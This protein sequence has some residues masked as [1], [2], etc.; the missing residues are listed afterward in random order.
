MEILAYIKELLLLNDCVIIPGFGGFVSN[1]KPATVR[2][3][4]FNPP[5]KAISFNEKLTFNDGLLINHL[6]EKEGSNYLVVSK[7]VGLLAQELNYRLTDGE[8]IHIEGI[9]RLAFDE[10]ESLTFTPEENQNFNLDSYGLAT[11][12]YETL[13][14]KN[15]VRRDISQEER[16]AVQ[17]FFQKRSLKKVLVAIPILVA[18]ALVPI[19]NNTTNL[20]KSNLS[21]L[22]QMM[23]RTEIVQKIEPIRAVV[24]ETVKAEEPTLKHSY[25]IIG[26]SFR[27]KNNA[28]KFIRQKQAEGFNA[29]NIGV[30]KGLHYIALDSF[31][32]FQ[33][34]KAAQNKIKKKSPGSGVW[35]YAKR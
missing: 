15:L 23:S 2:S 17:V 30:I 28:G 27:S 29:Q 5:S 6:V 25:F 31:A 13:H 7:Q 33:E 19:K 1:Y 9:G 14:A 24:A 16:D 32:S 34:A 10:N 35:I 20:Q 4:Q 3:T 21:S 12:N 22:S 26:G 11:F 18:L 8:T